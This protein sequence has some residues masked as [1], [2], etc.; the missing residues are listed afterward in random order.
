M[1]VELLAFIP[2]SARVHLFVIK[3]LA[4]VCALRESARD[5][6]ALSGIITP[7]SFLYAERICRNIRVRVKMHA[8]GSLRRSHA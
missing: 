1:V 2:L 6:L 7:R 5:H 4:L 8:R 3:R